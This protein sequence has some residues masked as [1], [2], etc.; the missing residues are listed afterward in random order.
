LVEP[1]ESFAKVQLRPRGTRS[2]GGTG[3]LNKVKDTL[4]LLLSKQRETLLVCEQLVDSTCLIGSIMVGRPVCCGGPTPDH[5]RLNLVVFP[6]STPVPVIVSTI[7]LTL[8]IFNLN[9]IFISQIIH[10]V[11][12]VPCSIK[13]IDLA[14]RSL[15]KM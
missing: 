1:S 10:P 4:L 12:H 5:S 15:I 3:D 2:K 14:D 11:A 6:P 13:C 8:F 9:S 7:H